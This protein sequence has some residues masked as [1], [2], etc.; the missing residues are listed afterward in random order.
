MV[1]HDVGNGSDWEYYKRRS[2]LLW[3]LFAE[4]ENVLTRRTRDCDADCPEEAR[5]RLRY[6]R[7]SKSDKVVS[8][9]WFISMYRVA[10]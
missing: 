2:E 9:D 10:S 8:T 5:G 6:E 1:K 7:L 3:L 4:K